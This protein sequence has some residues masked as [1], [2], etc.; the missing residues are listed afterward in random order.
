[1]HLPRWWLY[2]FYFTIAFAVVYVVNYHLLPKP[3]FGQPGM[4]A[5][6]QAEVLAAEAAA[7]A[8]GPV[9]KTAAATVALTDAASLA[10]GKAIF[11]GPEN[12]CSS[13][14]RPDLG[15][16]VGPNLTDD[17]WLHGCSMQEVI[18]SVTTGYPLKGMLPFGTGKPLTDEQ[19]RAGGE[20]R[21][22]P[23]RWRGAQSQAHRARA[24]QGLP[25]TSDGDTR[26]HP[27]VSEEHDAFR[28][29]L[30]SVARDGRRKWIYARKP[31][32]TPVPLPD[33]FELGAAR[34]PLPRAVHHGRRPAADDAQRPRAAVRAARHALPPAGFL[35][36]RAYR[37]DVPRDGRA[38]HG[39]LRP[40]LVRVA[41]PADHLHGDAVPQARILHRRLGGT[42]AQ[43]RPR[44]LDARQT[45]APRG[46]ARHLL[47]LV[48]RHRQR[49]PGLDHRRASIGGNRH[50]S[51]RPAHRRPG[52]NRDLQLRVLHGVRPVQGAGA[53]CSP[54]PT[55]ACSRH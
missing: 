34:V 16:L 27:A 12:V 9:R 24:R 42:A 25:L 4:I 17:Y 29:E 41:L 44:S 39:R 36:R 37:A 3:V 51:A 7:A 18:T 43:A 1:M 30:A 20:L 31:S 8:R 50:G 35:P 48:L 22:V 19:L 33:V 40:D 45:V 46:Q 10:K 52:R 26:G 5:E 6:Y 13:C 28:N 38:Q 53:A 23:A 14:H 21:P 54:V 32:G 55:A 49:V 11:E 2:G 15:G 47:R